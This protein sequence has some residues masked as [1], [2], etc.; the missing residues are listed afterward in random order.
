MLMLNFC[1]STLILPVLTML[2]SHCRFPTPA[3][4]ASIMIPPEF[5]LKALEAHGFEKPQF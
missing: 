1:G 3:L 4:L 2:K 5:S